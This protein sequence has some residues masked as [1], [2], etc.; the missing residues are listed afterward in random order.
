MVIFIFSIGWGNEFENRLK[1]ERDREYAELQ[2]DLK[3]RNA[4][5]PWT[6]SPDQAFSVPA[7]NAQSLIWTTDRDPADVVLRRTTALLADLADALPPET[8]QAMRSWMNEAAKLEPRRASFDAICLVRRQL[9]LRNPLLDFDEIV[10]AKGGGGWDGGLYH[11]APFGGFKEQAQ[12][13]TRGRPNIWTVD[14]WRGGF[15]FDTPQ[16]EGEPGPTSSPGIF[17]ASGWRESA[18]DVRPLLVDAVIEGG[19][20]DGK[21]LNAFPGR[22]HFAFDLSYDG[23]EIVFAR[24]L[25]DEAPLHIWR[26]AL[27]GSTV[28]Q[29]TDSWFPD[30]E[31]AVLPNG[32][33]VFV[34]LRR[35][36]AARCQSTLPQPCGTM[37]SMAGDGCDLYPI[38]WHET[39]EQF[40]IVANDGRLVYSRW[41]YIDRATIAAHNLWTCYP[42]GRDPRA[43]HG[44]YGLPNARSQ[45][46]NLRNRVI[47]ANSTRAL[48]MLDKLGKRKQPTGAVGRPTAEFHVRPIPN[49][50]GRYVGIASVH[51]GSGFGTPIL[52]DTNVPDDGMMSQVRTVL[53]AGIPVELALSK[54][55]FPREGRYCTPWPLSDK[56]FLVTRVPRDGRQRRQIGSDGV[57]LID[58][59]GNT[60]LLIPDPHAGPSARPLRARSKPPEI[61]TATW[62]GERSGK[63]GHKRAVISI[64][65]AY[66]STKPWPKDTKLKAV[67]II[68]ILSIPWGG[69][70]N[71]KKDDGKDFVNNFKVGGYSYPHGR[72]CMRMVLGVVPLEDDGSAY[73]E[74]PVG[75]EIYF[76]VLDEN[77]MAVQSMRSG[78]YV[79]Q[80]EHL[81]CR[82]CHRTNGK[83]PP[84]LTRTPLALQRAPSKINPAPEGA[85]PLSYGLLVKPVLERGCIPC[86]KKENAGGAPK[87]SDVRALRGYVGGSFFGGVSNWTEADTHPGKFGARG[88]KLGSL[89]ISTHK[90]RVSPEDK[91]RIITWLDANAMR[92][93]ALHHQAEQDQGKIVWPLLDV[94]PENPIGTE[95]KI[96]ARQ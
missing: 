73:F 27:D 70:R 16:R 58:H 30:W 84:P 32:R 71:Q 68:Q 90:D 51:H 15:D 82:G 37:F 24:A 33:I 23:K 21:V 87:D 11:M 79:H 77:G 19:R 80:G 38:S 94:D 7:A 56:Y 17:V 18:P 53:G 41:D 93:G 1:E 4:A 6:Y 95:T 12:G 42:D 14:H 8:V 46:E 52:I 3:S 25:G 48:A 81:S 49:M 45:D 85:T 64:V 55:F 2:E 54:R 29:L 72:S 78:T 10:Y 31:P 28:K 69:Y 66:E 26:A 35:W 62:Q 67:R 34:S 59:F 63:P 60:E 91:G 50:L 5:D 13:K 61:P 74:A 36:I 22:H 43:P 9:A 47:F 57:F 75:K 88:C 89:M 86:H 65:D 20:H 83:V 40:P 76:Q 39:S 96:P 44:N 92:Y